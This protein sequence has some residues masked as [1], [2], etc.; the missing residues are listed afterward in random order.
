MFVAKNTH[1]SM[2]NLRGNHSSCILTGIGPCTTP[3]R[4]RNFGNQSPG[5]RS[6]EIL[7]Q[8]KMI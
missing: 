3:A 2:V 8:I 4:L 5:S 7:D 6:P 1:L